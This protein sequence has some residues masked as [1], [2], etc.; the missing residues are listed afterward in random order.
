LC[1]NIRIFEQ[2]LEGVNP[3]ISQR[4]IKSR[5][6]LDFPILWFQRYVVL[7]MLLIYHFIFTYLFIIHF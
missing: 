2:F 4:E 5:I 7:S 6:T 1:I 3:K